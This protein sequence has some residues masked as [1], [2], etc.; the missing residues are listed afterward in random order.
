[1]TR[2]LSADDE[3]HRQGCQQ[4]VE[5]ELGA[6]RKEE[7]V[8]THVTNVLA[9]SLE[10]EMDAGQEKKGQSSKTQRD[11]L[12]IAKAKLIVSP[13]AGKG[14]YCQCQASQPIGGMVGL[15]AL[16]RLTRID[17]PNPKLLPTAGLL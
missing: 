17:C 6:L 12:H 4:K 5:K 3:S 13:K 10:G 16:K 15:S 2:L 7:P 11:K 9:R 1:M 8:Q 14:P